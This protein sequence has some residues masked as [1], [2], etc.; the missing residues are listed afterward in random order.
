MCLTGPVLPPCIVNKRNLTG[1][2]NVTEF[3][4]ALGPARLAAMGALSAAFAV[5][6]TVALFR[7]LGAK[8]TR[9]IAQIVAAV[10]GAS[11]VIE[12]FRNMRE[13]FSDHPFWVLFPRAKR[14]LI[15]MSVLGLLALILLIGYM[16]QNRPS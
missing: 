8:R 6:L 1:V 4:K 2:N 14:D 11:F 16:M 13:V 9:L 7:V 12:Y 5:T 15:V 10:V 3:I